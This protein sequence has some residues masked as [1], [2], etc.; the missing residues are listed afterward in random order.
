MSRAKNVPKGKLIFGTEVLGH[1]ASN[2]FLGNFSWCPT[3][4][5]QNQHGV[6]SGL[7]SPGAQIS[8][9]PLLWV[10]LQEAVGFVRREHGGNLKKYLK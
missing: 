8:T 1:S 2:N 9:D 6:N 3:F 10:S 7:P 4:K 5:H